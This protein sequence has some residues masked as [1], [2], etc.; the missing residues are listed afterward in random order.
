VSIHAFVGKRTLDMGFI[1]TPV[2][3]LIV[4]TAGLCG[5]AGFSPSQASG[6]AVLSDARASFYNARFA[7]AAS[8]TL[9]RCAANDIEGCELRSSALLMEMNRAIG[10]DKDKDKAF[11]ACATCQML[12]DTFVRDTRAGQ[13]A[14]RAK[15]KASPTDETAL[16]LLGKLDLNWVWL[17][18][19]TLGHKTGWNEYWEA[20]RSLDAVL[21]GN[22]RHV[23]A[24]V[25]RA[26]IDYIVDTRL[27]RGT[28][29][30]LGG[31]SKKRA[32]AALR[33]AAMADADV[34]TK[35]EARFGL[36]DMLVREK[37]FS[38]AVVVARDLARDF[39][40]NT[41]LPKFLKAHESN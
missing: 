6:Q 34:F 11:E 29:W 39:P 31:G 19:G 36:W 20:R 14:A 5:I 4:L 16:F 18:A 41:D 26:W 17:Q 38:E 21:K 10:D 37:S 40:E 35:A 27:P 22:P 15:V 8:L 23:R 32:L 33:E 13:A 12:L 28:R 7:E 30:V 9:D 25:A 2:S 3:R 1:T 24:K